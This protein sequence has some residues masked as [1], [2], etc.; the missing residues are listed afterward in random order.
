MQ[1]SDGELFYKISKGRNP[2]PSFESKLTEQERWGMV[3]YIRTF[4]KG[5]PAKKK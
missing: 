1:T 4:L 5:P 2:M 3:L